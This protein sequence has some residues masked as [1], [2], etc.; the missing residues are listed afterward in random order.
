VDG[1]LQIFFVQRPKDFTRQ[2]CLD[3][4]ANFIGFREIRGQT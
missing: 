2:S 3:S 1:I 4:V